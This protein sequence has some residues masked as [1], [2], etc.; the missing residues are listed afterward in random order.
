MQTTNGDDHVYKKIYK[1]NPI[2]NYAV[3]IFLSMQT[4]TN[5]KPLFTLI[6][7]FPSN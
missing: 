7:C 6:F 3:F 2:N 5:I 4:I 1:N